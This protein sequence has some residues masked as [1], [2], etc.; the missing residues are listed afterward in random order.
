MEKN[1]IKY[2]IDDKLIRQMPELHG[3]LI[4][5][6]PPRFKEIYVDAE[7]FENLLYLWEFFNNF[8]DYLNLP[9]FSLTELE[10]ALN[11]TRADDQVHSAFECELD[12]SQEITN[13]PFQGYT[14]HQKCTITEIKEHGFNLVNQLHCAVIKALRT[15]LEILNSNNESG[16]NAVNVKNIHSYNALFGSKSSPVP[17]NHQNALLINSI[18]KMDECSTEQLWPELIRL[19]VV[20]SDERHDFD[21]ESLNDSQYMADL[22]RKLGTLTPR[23]Y[24]WSLTRKEKVDI[25]MFLVD[26]IHDLDSF[27]HFL[28]KRLDDKSQLFKQ[29]N[30][31]HAEIKKLEQEKQ[32]YISAFK[33]DNAEEAER[34]KKEIDELSEKLLSATRVESR[35]IN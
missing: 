2:P 32:E 27:R 12:S 28:S 1:T 4:L 17:D 7:H 15:D 26:C 6:D 16:Q 23:S 11:F 25:L 18:L 30:D 34:I 10:A 31:L 3:Q 19:L 24:T 20:H 21:L 13:D 9:T 8:S 35:W 29:R 5:K 33:Q 22:F 14:W